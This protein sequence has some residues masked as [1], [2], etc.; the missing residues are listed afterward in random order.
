M[1]ISWIIENIDTEI[2]NQYLE[3]TIVKDLRKGIET[4]LCSGRD[5]LQIFDLST[6]AA[7]LTQGKNT[8]E[9]FYDQLN[10]LWKDIDRRMLNPIECS[11]DITT[12]N[13]YIRRQRIDQFLAGIDES[14]DKKN[15][16][17][18]TKSHFPL[19]KLPQQQSGENLL[20]GE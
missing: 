7:T 17:Y 13:N 2:V 12:F 14:L 3:Y 4:L 8:I 16:I 20:A 10:T 11:K 18:S 15:E 1:V 6:K 19:W 5:E 9:H